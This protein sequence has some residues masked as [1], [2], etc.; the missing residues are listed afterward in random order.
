MVRK[1]TFLVVLNGDH[2]NFIHPTHFTSILQKSKISSTNSAKIMSVYA[3]TTEICMVNVNC[4]EILK[5]T[6]HGISIW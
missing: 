6:E 5:L 1:E 4:N 2:K 3:F